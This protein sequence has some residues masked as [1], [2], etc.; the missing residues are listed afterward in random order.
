SRALHQKY[1]EAMQAAFSGRGRKWFVRAIYQEWH[2]SRERFQ[3]TIYLLEPNLKEG[4][5]GLRDVHSVF[6]TLFGLTGGTEMKDL[7]EQANLDESQLGDYRE[8]ISFIETI[9]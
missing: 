4:P 1:W 2:A 7:A 9:R 5:G 6:W 8:A 3:S